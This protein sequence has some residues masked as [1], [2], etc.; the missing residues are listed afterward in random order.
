MDNNQQGVSP[1]FVVGYP[2]L[3]GMA[4]GAAGGYASGNISRISATPALEYVR[5]NVQMS[6]LDPIAFKRAYVGPQTVDPVVSV[7]RSLPGGSKLAPSQ[8]R[9]ELAS[10]VRNQIARVGELESKGINGTKSALKLAEA[11]AKLLAGEE[12]DNLAK[13]E[14]LLLKKMR[15]YLPMVEKQ[16]KYLPTLRAI[17]GGA[18]GLGAGTAL[19]L[20]INHLRK[21]KHDA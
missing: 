10:V 21:G 2:S 9:Q 6:K 7:F 16:I 17:K 12:F 5:K 19:G 15:R 3:A 4:L 8:K 1:W 13:E 18:I 11:R 20:L 14:R